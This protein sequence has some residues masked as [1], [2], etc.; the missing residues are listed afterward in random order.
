M[1]RSYKIGILL[2]A[3]TVSLGTFW[4]CKRTVENGEILGNPK[5]ISAPGDFD[6]IINN[7]GLPLTRLWSRAFTPPVNQGAPIDKNHNLRFAPSSLENVFFYNEFSHV[8]TWYILLEGIQSGAQKSF[9]STS[10]TLDSNNTFWNGSADGTR[11]F[12]KGEK[13]K[14]TLSF[15]GSSIT[16]SD[17]L[18]IDGGTQGAIRYNN[19]IK[20]LPNGDT[21]KYKLIDDMEAEPTPIYGI[22]TTYSDAA[23]GNGKAAFFVNDKRQVGGFFSFYMKGTDNNGN[24]YCGGSSGE[25]LTELHNFTVEQDPSKVYFNA[26]VYGFGRPNSSI[27]FQ[28]F[29]NDFADP[30]TF[31]YPLPR[32]VDKNDMWFSI[33]EV[34]WVGWKLVSVPYS[35]FMPA[36]NPLSGGGGNRIKEPHKLCGFGLELESYPAPGATVELA[37]DDVY[38]TVNGPFQP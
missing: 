22:R 25:A 7:G 8:V 16:Y 37:V 38:L 31:S 9:T 10:N 34:D 36:N 28:A 24:S 29:E 18:S 33:I 13:V 4:A 1:K 30:S 17:T 15:L 11:F 20:I 2:L 21:L 23:D 14:Y 26:Y 27:F 12:V 6:G 3:L 5:L 19:R 32:A 35:S